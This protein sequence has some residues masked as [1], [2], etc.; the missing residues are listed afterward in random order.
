MSKKGTLGLTCAAL[1]LAATACNKDLTGPASPNPSQS[2]SL[3]TAESDYLA[4]QSDRMMDG[5]LGDVFSGQSA[6]ASAAPS[7][8]ASAGVSGVP[9]TTTFSFERTRPCPISG[10]IVVSGS[11]QFVADRETATA[12]M[13]V[14][15]TRTIDACAFVHGDVTLTLNGEGDFDAYWKRVNREL[16]EAERNAS[17]SFEVTTSD[18][19]SK[20]CTYELHAVYDPDTHSVHVTGNF[21]G[22]EIDRT[23]SRD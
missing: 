6:S 23:W 16:V 9:I 20:S 18:G 11:G 13:S 1:L 17:G 2:Q 19:R 10:Q 7:A 4:V 14:E 15:G 8:A 21:C 5:V 3:T 12:E 22:R